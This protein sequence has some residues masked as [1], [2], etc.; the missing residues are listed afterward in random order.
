MDRDDKN[1]RE[2]FEDEAPEELS[3][4]EET[5]GMINTKWEKTFRLEKAC[6]EFI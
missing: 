2:Q 1:N 4:R 5:G 3:D 6:I